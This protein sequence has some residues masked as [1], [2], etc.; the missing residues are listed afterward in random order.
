MRRKGRVRDLR[1][2]DFS[3]TN[4]FI[5]FF[6]LSSGLILFVST[7]RGCRMMFRLLLGIFVLDSFFGVFGDYYVC[8]A[9]NNLGGARDR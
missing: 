8:T 2:C 5:F 9:Q 4:S 1:D 3:Q 6:L 7:H